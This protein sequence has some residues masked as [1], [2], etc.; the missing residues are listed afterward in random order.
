MKRGFGS[1]S[2]KRFDRGDMLQI[3]LDFPAQCLIARDIVESSAIKSLGKDFTNIVFSGV[4][5]SAMG[6]DILKSYLYRES[7]VP[8]SVIRDYDLPAFIDKNTLL[9]I[10]SYSGN[11]EEAFSVWQQAKNRGLRPVVLSSGGR[12]EELARA[13]DATFILLPKGLPPRFALG[14][15]SMVPLCILS[16]LGIIEDQAAHIKAAHEVLE[17]LAKDCLHPRIAVRDNVAKYVAQK[18]FNKLTFIYTSSIH[19]D[20]VGMRLRAQ[21]AE[22]PKAIASNHVFPEMNHNEIAAWQNPRKLLK[23]CVLVFLRDKDINPRIVKRIELTKDLLSR[24]G[25]RV[26]EI[27][28]R[29]EEILSKIFSLIYIGDFI[30]YYLALLYGVDPTPVERISYIKEELNKYKD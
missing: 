21:L 7:S 8:I 10:S 23:D 5:A 18:L 3:L 29:G 28:S 13:D 22:N 1:D 6:G 14:Y 15:L 4:G 20:V 24:E 11:T 12:L 17:A 25:L 19:F 2:I 27:W 30:S 16:R 9:F 26:V